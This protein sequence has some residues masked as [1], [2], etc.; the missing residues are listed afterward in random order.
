MLWYSELTKH[1]WKSYWTRLSF[2]F[3]M[4]HVKYLNLYNDWWSAFFAVFLMYKRR[5]YDKGPASPWLW[6]DSV[7]INDGKLSNQ[8]A[9][10]ACVA[11]RRLLDFRRHTP[12]GRPNFPCLNSAGDLRSHGLTWFYPATGYGTFRVLNQIVI[13]LWYT[14]VSVSVLN[15][16]F[17]CII[18]TLQHL[19]ISSISPA[20]FWRTYR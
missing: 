12:L 5:W 9:Y 1:T 8:R 16:V 19:I 14:S 20:L 15:L 11:F 2:F 17:N 13:L 18:L 3:F 4:R 10:C 6:S 7:L